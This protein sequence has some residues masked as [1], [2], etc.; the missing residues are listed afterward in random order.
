MPKAAADIKPSEELVHKTCRLR[1]DQLQWLESRASSIRANHSYVLRS[2]ID[3]AMSAD[4][5][6][7][8]THSNLK[9]ERQ[10]ARQ[11][12]LALS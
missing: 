9:F 2:L 5:E 11:A 7:A 6:F 4:L 8:A 12:R 3:A 10:I 1:S